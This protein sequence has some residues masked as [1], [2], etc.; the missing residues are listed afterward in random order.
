MAPRSGSMA[1]SEQATRRPAR[2]ATNITQWSGHVSLHARE[3]VAAEIGRG[4]VQRVG[5]R[6]ALVEE[7]PK[8]GVDRRALVGA[9]AD[10]GL[11]HATALLRDLLALVALQ[12]GQELD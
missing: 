11:E 9:E 2:C 8:L 3:E 4:M 7:V 5:Q 10:A 6:V 12:A 1:S